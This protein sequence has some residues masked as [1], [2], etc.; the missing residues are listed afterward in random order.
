MPTFLKRPALSAYDYIIVG[1]GSAGS[2]LAAR[3]SEDKSKNVLLIEAGASDRNIFIQMPAGLGIPLMKD[4]YNWK[5]FAESNHFTDSIEGPYTPRG[6]VLGGSSSINGMNWVRGNKADYDHWGDYGLPNWSYAHCLPY[7]KR[8]ENC[9]HGDPAYRGKNG[10]TSVIKAEA[11]NPLF[12][13]FIKAS[14]EYG[15]ALNHDHNGASQIGVH[16]TQRNVANGIRHSASQAY[17]YDQPD[18]PNLEILLETRCTAIEFSGTDAVKVHL[19]RR[20]EKFSV[21]V[22]GELILSAGAIQ[23]PQL[24]M[25]AG[26]GDANMLAD[27]GISVRQ[28]MSGIGANLQDHPAWCFDYGATNPRDSLAS[29]LSYFGRLKIGMEW[30]L[31]KRGLGVS[32]HFEVGA[33]LCLT[34]N[35]TIPEVQMEC[36]AMRGDFAPEGITIDPGYQCFTSIQRPTSRGKVWIESAD[37]TKAPKFQFNYLSTDY[38]RDIAIAAIKATREIF[39]QPAWNGRLTPELSGVHQLKSNQDI[40]QWAYTHIESN[41]HPCGTCRM[42]TDDEAV[43]DEAGKVHGFNNLRV[44][45]ASIIPAIPAGNLN[46]VTI[47]IAEKIADSLLGISALE[48]EYPQHN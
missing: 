6:R 42:G 8:S 31:G 7:F 27:T 10:P 37:P 29:K 19:D 13:A 40:M 2:V 33:F 12:Q 24:L 21:E 14:N 11:N 28:H 45:D 30:L 38:D 23:S 48:P 26:I 36:I 15:L 39:Q 43:T 47:M 44:V 3:L 22:A 9:G 32:N 41:Y 17:L 4:R 25:L 5:F 46:A 16:K 20:G 18:K 1:S 34:E 35:E